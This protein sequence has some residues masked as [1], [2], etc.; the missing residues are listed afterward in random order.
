MLYLKCATLEACSSFPMLPVL[1]T[2]A[3]AT[4]WSRA[5][6]LAFV[7]HP[8][9]VQLGTG[10]LP[11]GVFSRCLLGR[12]VVLAALEQ[13]AESTPELRGLLAA[14]SASCGSDHA[15]WLD[16]AA[17]AG[18]TIELPPDEIEAG[19]RCYSCGGTHYNVD[20]PKDA[21]ASPAANALASYLRDCSTLA[22][23]AAI[24]RTMGWSHN[25]L[26][27][28]GLDGGNAYRGWVRAHASRWTLIA[29]AC[30][31][32]LASVPQESIMEEEAMTATSLLYAFVDAEAGVSGLL[33]K[34]SEGMT[35]R[36][37]REKL[38]EVEPGFLATQDRNAAFLK[39]QVLGQ[40][41]KTAPPGAAAVAV[42]AAAGSRAGADSGAKTAAAKLQAAQAY[43]DAKRAAGK[44]SPG[45]NDAAAA[46]R[47]ARAASGPPGKA[48]TG[49]KVFLEQRR[50]QQAAAAYLAEKKRKQQA[51]D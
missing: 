35:L 16:Q 14:E 33:D 21:S 7:N 25:T 38:E 22:A 19:V 45:S 9:V 24:F 51:G 43:L 6:G 5:S 49:A 46:I 8:L 17:A 26:L 36:E 30:D 10:A 23:P 34:V 50:K 48:Q 4:A 2:A 28:A 15:A 40:Q 32:A 39:E 27:K 37:G 31:A 42:A 3:I 44:S 29:D 12:E 20:C 41:L 11:L 13:C 18:K 1:C 47:A